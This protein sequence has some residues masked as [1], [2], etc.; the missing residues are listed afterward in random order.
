MKTLYINDK[1]VLI[2]DENTSFPMTHTISD[3][4]NINV[5]GIASSKS[6]SIPR[7]SQND[8]IFGYIADITRMNV[9]SDDYKIGVC[10]NQI[11]KTNYTL[12]SNN[13]IVSKG[14]VWIDNITDTTYDITL[15]DE[16]LEKVEDLEG[17]EDTEEYYLTSCE[18]PVSGSTLLNIKST[19]ENINLMNNGL[20][21]ALK[22]IIC[23]KD[24]DA[25]DE[26]TIRCLVAESSGGTGAMAN[27]DLPTDCSSLQ[28][29][30][31]KNWEVNY[32]VPINNVVEAINYTYPNTLV[33]DDELI[34]MFNE[35]NMLC[36]S[37]VNDDISVD[38]FISSDYIIADPKKVKLA[39]LTTKLKDKT[40]LEYI[41]TDGGHKYLQLYYKFEFTSIN[42]NS[43]YISTIYDSINGV[44][45]YD[46]STPD[47]TIVSKI[48]LKISLKS[49][50]GLRT[51]PTYI[52]IDVIKGVNFTYTVDENGYLQTGAVEGICILDTD[53][54]PKFISAPYEYTDLIMELC[55]SNSYRNFGFVVPGS[56]TTTYQLF[57]DGYVSRID[58]LS[59]D[60]HISSLLETNLEFRT[61][62]MITTKKIFPKVSI[63]SFI[64]NLTKF[65][66]LDL[67]IEDS[68]LKIQ[69]KKYYLT[70]EVLLIDS[71]E[72][73]TTNNITFDKLVLTTALPDS[74]V[75][76][77]Y[78]DRKKKIYGEQV[79][80]TGYSIK[81]NKKEI[82]LEAAVPF[83]LKDYNSF[84]YDRF[85]NYRNAG[86]AKNNHGVI[87]ELDDKLVFG[88]LGNIVEDIY[89]TND[90]PY[91]AGMNT[92]TISGAT[93]VKFVHY[94]PLIKVVSYDS[95][96]SDAKWEI[97]DTTHTDVVKLLNYY[98]FSPY[99]YTGDNITKSLEMNKPIVNYAGIK[100]VNYPDTSTLYYRFHRNMLIDKYD[101]NTHIL[102][103]NIYVDGLID[104]YKIYNYKN[105]YYIISEIVEVDYTK[106]GI[107]QVKL[108]RVNNIENYINNIIL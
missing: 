23:I 17:D 15:Y 28:L 76:D 40:T 54:Y 103:A 74:D 73:I 26:G 67:A 87:T 4:E 31:L 52:Q 83:M 102:T 49:Q 1:R 56:E 60:T 68:K 107:Y 77:T 88:Y 62:D 39:G 38:S 11:K 45:H 5:I 108:M 7:N 37:P 89:I 72:G 94:N 18:L 57:S 78:E 59:D 10:F 100:N 29:R 84:T 90:S 8:E 97:L 21:S 46:T 36:K 16:I 64:V 33:V 9:N 86:Y 48:I 35:V 14:L 50:S 51:A 32:A 63:K 91:E 93:E 13:T 42:K 104:I 55:Y 80:N 98:T 99:I 61:N 101:S 58:L 75:L 66:N 81:K 106:S 27:Y 43:N 3:L 44:T 19:A 41:C 69:P 105:S 2:D 65:F 34:P 85:C 96:T 6:V 95:S 30:T 79:I 25:L 47:G 82:K 92:T 12:Y 24:S 22:P 20:Y 70:D 53:F 71:I